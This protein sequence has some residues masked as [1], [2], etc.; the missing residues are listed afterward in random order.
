MYVLHAPSEDE[1]DHLILMGR[2]KR[3]LGVY[4]PV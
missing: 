1:Y 3:S 4:Q 2:M